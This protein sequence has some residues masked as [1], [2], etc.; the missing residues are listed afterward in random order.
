[1]KLKI[2]VHYKGKTYSSSKEIPNKDHLDAQIRYPH[3]IYRDKTTYT[4]KAKH[5][6]KKTDQQD[7]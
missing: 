5:K 4:R 3:L 2:N 1:M 7:D 6:N